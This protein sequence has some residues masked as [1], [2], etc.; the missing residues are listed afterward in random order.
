MEVL[1]GP[2]RA[3][4]QMGEVK[5]GRGERWVG[6]C[7]SEDY[8]AAVAGSAVG[9]TGAMACLFR[10]TGAAVSG[11]FSGAGAPALGARGSAFSF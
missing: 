11:R 6:H 8:Y 3:I 7:L 9:S 2:P 1:L 10:G 4:R 5:D